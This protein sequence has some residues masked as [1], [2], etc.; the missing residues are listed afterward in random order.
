MARKNE[1]FKFSEQTIVFSGK[2]YSLW[3][4]RIVTALGAAGLKSL[5]H[6][7]EEEKKYLI[8]TP[9]TRETYMKEY[10][11]MQDKGK[12][13]IYDRISNYYLRRIRTCSTIKEIFEK[14]DRDFLTPGDFDGSNAASR[15]FSLKYTMGKNMYDYLAIYE[16]LWDEYEEI[17]RYKK[18]SEGEMIDKDGAEFMRSLKIELLRSSVASVT[19]IYNTANCNAEI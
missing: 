12:A 1:T 9:A 7:S 6:E 8:L 10:D 19:D 4:T 11:L 18:K 15:C 5:L 14:L 13:I 2:H 3:R 16:T 17:L